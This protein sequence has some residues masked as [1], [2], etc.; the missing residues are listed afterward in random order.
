MELARAV[1]IQGFKLLGT[2]GGCDA[3]Y[4]IGKINGVSGYI[5]ITGE[6]ELNIPEKPTEPTRLGVYDLETD[7]DK[8][9]LDFPTCIECLVWCMNN[10]DIDKEATL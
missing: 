6:N 9:T 8:Y 1:E 4:A 2:G 3:Y 7:E 5:L 10:V